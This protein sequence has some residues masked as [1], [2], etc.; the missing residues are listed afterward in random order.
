MDVILFCM[1]EANFETRSIIVPCTTKEEW[2][3]DGM[4]QLK[5]VSDVIRPNTYIYKRKVYCIKAFDDNSFNNKI[6]DDSDSNVVDH[7]VD[8]MIYISE[9]G[10]G[11]WENCIYNPVSKGFDHVKNFEMGMSMKHFKAQDINVKYGFLV[12][13]Q[14]V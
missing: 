13:A 11:E 14:F 9:W 4:E 1:Q 6:T 5:N 8:K 3:L 10:K 7:F 2:F 12:I